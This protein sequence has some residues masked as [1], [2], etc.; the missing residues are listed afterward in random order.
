MIPFAPNCFC[1]LRSCQSNKR[2]TVTYDDLGYVGDDGKD[3]CEVILIMCVIVV[4]VVIL[5]AGCR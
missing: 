1:F 4:T 5:R 2:E 3:A